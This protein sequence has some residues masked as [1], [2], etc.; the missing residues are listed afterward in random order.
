MGVVSFPPKA[1]QEH[2]KME[3]AA[4]ANGDTILEASPVHHS[5]L[6]LPLMLSIGSPDFA[7]GAATGRGG[8]NQ[9]TTKLPTDLL[10]NQQ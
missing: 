2:S 6:H 10:P 4:N 7:G 9:A 1:L 8:T 5:D 3:T